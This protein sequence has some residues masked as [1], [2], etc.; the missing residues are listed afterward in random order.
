MSDRRN[1]SGSDPQ[2]PFSILPP[3]E[4]PL[5]HIPFFGPS[6]G[7]PSFSTWE[8]SLQRKDKIVRNWGSNHGLALDAEEDT[9]IGHSGQGLNYTEKATELGYHKEEKDMECHLSIFL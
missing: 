4:T 5:K 8:P 7:A 3:K 6:Q 1:Q 2:H 9:N